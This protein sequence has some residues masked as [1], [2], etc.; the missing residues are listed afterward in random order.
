ME[1]G[2]LNTPS[3]VGRALVGSMIECGNGDEGVVYDTGCAYYLC[4]MS[5]S[6]IKPPSW[7]TMLI[8]F[9]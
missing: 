3:L 5:C 8:D 9:L 7:S 2:H 4:A 1:R 6:S